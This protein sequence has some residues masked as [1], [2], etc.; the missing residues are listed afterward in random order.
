MLTDGA[1]CA[2]WRGKTPSVSPSLVTSLE[3]ERSSQ[4]EAELGFGSTATLPCCEHY[5][6]Y[7]LNGLKEQDKV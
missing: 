5:A 3:T 2:H 6:R 4:L 7:V 1:L